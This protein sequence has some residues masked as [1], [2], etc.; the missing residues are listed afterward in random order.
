MRVFILTAYLLAGIGFAGG[1][2][3]KPGDPGWHF[4]GRVALWPIA[5]GAAISD[6]KTVEIELACK[7]ERGA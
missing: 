4:W 7:E 1:Y 6:P 2:P 5:F 3:A